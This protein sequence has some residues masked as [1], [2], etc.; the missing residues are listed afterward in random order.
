MSKVK[1]LLSLLGKQ[2][3][4]HP[5]HGVSAGEN[6]PETV[7]AFIEIVPSDQVKYEVDKESGYLAIDRPHKFSN[8]VPAL[9]GFVPKTFCDKEVAA[10]CMEKSG[11]TGVEG[12]Q[13]PLDILVLTERD[14]PHGD[15]IVEAIPIGGFRM[16]DGGEADDK[17]IAV[18]K[19]DQV[20]GEW[21]DVSDIPAPI[22]NRLLHYFLTYK[23]KPGSTEKEIEIT[24]TYGKDEAFEVINR[25]IKDYDANYGDIEGKLV[26]AL[27]E[28][29]K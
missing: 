27:A 25:S 11:K 19:S 22:L 9:Y 17:I 3:K 15:L 26:E 13:D 21:K 29:C 12:D 18:L 6:I 14:V 24:H 2:F 1:D 7:N 10:Y 8:I 28:V 5:W 16:I 4:A 23:E 20:Y